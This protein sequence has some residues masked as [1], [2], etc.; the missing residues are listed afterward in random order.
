M[1]V[2]LVLIEEYSQSGSYPRKRGSNSGAW[3]L[4]QQQTIITKHLNSPETTHCH[5][6]RHSEFVLPFVCVLWSWLKLDNST[7]NR[8]QTYLQLV[9]YKILL[10]FQQLRT[11][12]RWQNLAANPTILTPNTSA[13]T[14][15]RRATFHFMIIFVWVGESHLALNE[16][17]TSSFHELRCEAE[18]IF[19][20]GAY[21]K[22]RVLCEV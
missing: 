10:V 14:Y 6:S 2:T 7:K 15:Y 22:D 12:Q 8:S 16:C 17:I 9:L 13:L 19:D 11:R 18:E 4:V 1:A 3:R 20:H 5:Q 21:N